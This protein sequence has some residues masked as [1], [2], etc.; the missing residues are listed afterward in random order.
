ML[1]GRGLLVT[2]NGIT[3]RRSKPFRAGKEVPETLR[4]DHT[5]EGVD[6]CLRAGLFEAVRNRAHVAAKLFTPLFTPQPPERRKG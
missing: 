4:G 2:L 3:G 6:R 5:D 1:S